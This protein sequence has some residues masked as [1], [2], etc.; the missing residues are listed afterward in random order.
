LGL[1]LKSAARTARPSR[2]NRLV[3]IRQMTADN[4][5][6]ELRDALASAKKAS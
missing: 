5:L 1:P 3:L 6:E 4:V 2:T